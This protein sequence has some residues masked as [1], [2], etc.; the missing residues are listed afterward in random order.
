MIQVGDGSIG[1]MGLLFLHFCQ[2]IAVVVGVI[3]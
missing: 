1:W 3:R 2:G